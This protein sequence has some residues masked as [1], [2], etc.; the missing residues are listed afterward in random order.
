MQN[1]G[2]NFNLFPFSYSIPFFHKDFLAN[3]IKKKKKLIQQFT[4]RRSNNIQKEDGEREKRWKIELNWQFNE[5]GRIYPAN[6][7]HLSII[8]NNEKEKLLS[9]SIDIIPIFLPSHIIIITTVA[10]F[11]STRRKKIIFYLHIH[12]RICFT[13]RNVCSRQSFR[14]QREEAAPSASKAHSKSSTTHWFK[15]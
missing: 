15:N 11:C 10:N 6:G 1:V 13:I 8:R 4:H 14:F 7:N 2:H 12:L 5:E 3:I 9:L